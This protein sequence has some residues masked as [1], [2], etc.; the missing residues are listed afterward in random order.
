M[1][2]SRMQHRLPHKGLRTALAVVL[3]LSM[4]LGGFPIPAVQAIADE[5]DGQTT[6]IEEPIGEPAEGEGAPDS[7]EPQSDSQDPQEGV[8]GDG[9]G[10]G[11]GDEQEGEGQPAEGE[12][13][14]QLAD[15]EDESQPADGESEG[16]EQPVKAPKAPKVSSDPLKAIVSN[17]SGLVRTDTINNADYGITM[18]LFD[19]VATD[20]GQNHVD[21]QNSNSV[22]TGINTGRANRNNNYLLFFDHG[23]IGTTINHYA[24]YNYNNNNLN[25]HDQYAM[26][27]IVKPNLIKENAADSSTWYPQLNTSSNES[28][29][30]LFEK[31]N[32]PNQK[33]VYEGVNNLFYPVGT[34]INQILEYD[35]NNYYAY[36]N[37]TGPNAG[38]F[39]VY[40]DT[41]QRWSGSGAEHMA[42]GFFPFDQYNTTYSKPNANINPVNNGPKPIGVNHQ[43]GMT[44]A[45]EITMPYEGKIYDKDTGQSTPMFFEFSGDD[46]M[47]VFIDGKLVLDVGGIHQPVKGTINFATG[48]VIVSSGAPGATNRDG[49]FTMTASNATV[50]TGPTFGDH[51]EMWNEGNVAGSLG[52]DKNDPT[53]RAGTKHIVQFF[54]LERGGCDSNLMLSTN[55]HLMAPKQ[56]EVR[57]NWSNIPEADRPDN[58]KVQLIRK[59]VSRDTKV[60]DDGVT[61]PA[62]VDYAPVTFE[63]LSAAELAAGKKQ[64]TNPATLDSTNSWDYLWSELPSEGYNASGVYDDS[65]QDS[66]Y[67]CD[68]TY[69][70]RELPSDDLPFVP[71]YFDVDADDNETQL[72]PSE[73]SYT[74]TYYNI[75]KNDDGQITASSIDPNKP[76]VTLTGEFVEAVE[77]DGKYNAIK[78]VNQPVTLDI[79]KQWRNAAG[80]NNDPFNHNA[81]NCTDVVYVKLLK[82]TVET[83]TINLASEGEDPSL[84]TRLRTDD[85]G[86]LIWGIAVAV[87]IDGKP[88][89]DG[90][91]NPITDI[92]DPTTA[93]A[94]N[95]GNNWNQTFKA[96]PGDNVRYTVVEG[97][98]ENNKF[99]PTITFNA[100]K[101]TNDTVGSP[102]VIDFTTYE[103][104]GVRKTGPQAEAAVLSRPGMQDEGGKTTAYTYYWQDENVPETDQANENYTLVRTFDGNA[105]LVQYG[106]KVTT[107]ETDT[108]DVVL[109][110]PANNG[111]SNYNLYTAVIDLGDKL[112][113]ADD[114]DITTKDEIASLS[115]T[116]NT[117]TVTVAPSASEKKTVTLHVPIKKAGGG[118]LS[119]IKSA[120][121]ATVNVTET[122]YIPAQLANTNTNV[123]QNLHGD[124]LSL[125]A[126]YTHGKA[127]VGNKPILLLKLRKVDG[128]AY[129]A[130]YKK[131]RDANPE[132]ST[133]T[134]EDFLKTYTGLDDDDY[135]KGAKFELYADDGEKNDDNQIFFDQDHDMVPARR[136][137]ER[138]QT[139]FTTGNDGSVTLPT[140]VDDGTYWLVETEAPTGYQC[141]DLERPIRI[142]VTDGVISIAAATA[143][144]E[145]AM[146]SANGVYTI[147]MPNVRLYMLP[148]AGGPGVYPYLIA[149]AFVAAYALSGFGGR[150]RRGTRKR[151]AQRI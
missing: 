57:K 64:L 105:K 14:E 150:S 116:G 136:I 22:N 36:Y 80:T 44:M 1:S 117:I 51:T 88:A 84:V 72:Y 123:S 21:N 78:L 45:V 125:D 99:K 62:Y 134:F 111:D 31:A 114:A 97:T 42:F 63:K 135:L 18:N 16:D 46:D 142:D 76:V 60:N 95:K 27:G 54:Y 119:T 43:F 68:Y 128:K 113:L 35:S 126:T 137:A 91:D 24:G 6:P 94:L 112:A 9:Q 124:Y 87:G 56:V 32:T 96:V 50:Q 102:Y 10:E 30:Y 109:E 127:T 73:V 40:Q 29:K 98:I 47:W 71:T 55:L 25:Y 38:K 138:G 110:V 70:V 66:N 41:Y 104:N 37:Q 89:L 140:L 48:D 15:G 82:Q 106:G 141:R 147:F 101:T 118:D 115:S 139:T 34:G 19:Y 77:E 23:T 145:P 90:A 143:D 39:S 7:Q 28:L 92:S 67:Y 12:G 4:I 81:D 13:D 59:A 79:E 93:I 3:S 69:L 11:E 144:T 146:T 83:E 65:N 33:T 129:A 149:G 58:I 49:K 133:T 148:A 75:T 107:H 130:A 52:V 122:V 2:N 103:R 121:A 85:Q 53:W 20:N 108:I 61:V 151:G 26:Q 74:R 8:A 5:L 132:G 86:N 131:Y 120:S 17:P 100:A